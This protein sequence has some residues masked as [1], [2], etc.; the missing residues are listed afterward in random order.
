MFRSDPEF[1]LISATSIPGAG[2]VFHALPLGDAPRVGSQ[3]EGAP[4]SLFPTLLL[5]ETDLVN[6][7][8]LALPSSGVTPRLGEAKPLLK[9]EVLNGP[10]NANSSLG[11]K[12]TAPTTPFIGIGAAGAIKAGKGAWAV[13]GRLASG[14]PPLSP[15]CG[16]AAGLAEG[17]ELLVTP[18]PLPIGRNDRLRCERVLGEIDLVWV[19]LSAAGCREEDL[20][21]VDLK[22]N[23]V[24][25]C[26]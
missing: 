3:E 13:E 15:L 21:L 19:K 17:N 7:I 8:L 2:G 1:R 25:S 16:H 4:A 23:S 12:S 26:T 20:D 9:V 14:R 10:G 6:D 24:S 18:L 11:D 5:V 22:S